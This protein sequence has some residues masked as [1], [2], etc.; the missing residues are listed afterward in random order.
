[1]KATLSNSDYLGN[2][3]RFIS[4]LDFNDEK[5]FTIYSHPKWV[6]VH[7][8]ILTIIASMA[9]KVGKENVRFDN[10]T[11]TSG[12]YLDRMGLFNFT[13]QPSPYQIKKKEASGRFIPLH[14]I[15]NST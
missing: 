7:P 5:I 10:L 4:N 11:A 3:Y 6:S 13:N 14:I 15:K 1:M 8:A 2:V 12:A 9:M